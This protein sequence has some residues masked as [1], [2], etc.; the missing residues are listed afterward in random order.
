MADNRKKHGKRGFHQIVFGRTMIILL[1]LAFHFLVFLAVIMYFTSAL[2]YFLGSITAVSA[3]ALIYI[4]NTRENPSLKLSWCVLIALFPIFGISLYFFVKMD[5]G[6]RIYRK[7]DQRA[8]EETRKYVP[9]QTG[10][11]EHIRNQEPELYP[12]AYY[13]NKYSGFGVCAAQEMR[14]FPVGEDMM[15]CLL[16]ELEKAEHYIFLEFF[17][18]TEGQMWGSILQILQKKAKQGV[19][20]RVMYDGTNTVNKLPHN[21]CRKLKKMGISCKIFSPMHPFVSTHYNNRDHRKIIVIDGKT[22]F[23]GGINLSDEYMNLIHP[24]GYWKD[25]AVMLRG[26]A[27]AGFSLMFLQMWNAMEKNPSYQ[28]YLPKMKETGLAEGFVIPFADTPTDQE[29]VGKTVYMNMINQAKRYVYIMTPYLILDGEM[30]TA[31]CQCAK[32]G[33]E[34]CLLQPSIP[35][36]KYAYVLARRHY[37][38]LMDAGIKIYQYTPGF[39]HAKVFLTDDIHGVVGTVNLDYRS[40]YLHYECAAYLYKTQVLQDMKQDFDKTFAVSHLMTGSDLK[41]EGIL[42]RLAGVLLKVVA[43]LM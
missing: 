36:H 4:L 24:Y 41:K 31:L 18:I 21:Y 14:Y 37:K 9:D 6:H 39:V 26:Q 33:V 27:A 5:L 22:A 10:I 8:M 29:R 2:P 12:M 13:L 16:E 28:P 35:D 40:L 1:L 3:V 38:E 32:R 23:T 11:M 7:I 17:I 15:P 34:V 42:S 19:E 30:I 20:I 43:P 25:T